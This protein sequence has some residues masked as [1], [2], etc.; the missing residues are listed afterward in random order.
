MYNKPHLS[1]ICWTNVVYGDTCVSVIYKW[2]KQVYTV[3]LNFASF[4][5]NKLSFWYLHIM[6]ICLIP[7]LSDYYR[8]IFYNF[9]CVLKEFQMWP[10][11]DICPPYLACKQH[12]SCYQSVKKLQ[13]LSVNQSLCIYMVER[14]ELLSLFTEFLCGNF[15][16]TITFKDSTKIFWNLYN[17]YFTQM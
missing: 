12:N 9:Y 6:D 15:I 2:N 8:L 1:N 16:R 4:P 7:H 11:E 3:W 10:L 17:F 13:H 14:T 5:F